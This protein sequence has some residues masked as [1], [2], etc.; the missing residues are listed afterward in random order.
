MSITSVR[1]EP[2]TNGNG[3]SI[4]GLIV[5]RLDLWTSAIKRKS[6][7]GRGSSSKIELYGIKKLRELILELAVRGLLVTQDGNDEPASALLTRIAAEKEKLANGGKGKK[8]KPLPKVGD[9]ECLFQ[10]PGGWSALRLGE[11]VRVIR[12]VSY[13]KQDAQF[14]EFEG[15]VPLL[16]ANNINGQLNFIDLLFIPS[17]LAKPEQLVVRG[18][19]LI[20]MSSGSS[21]LVG[22]AA[23][24]SEDLAST[25]GAFCAVLRPYSE[26]LFSFL[27]FFCKTPLYRS[28]TQA[29]GKGIGIQNLN[30]TGLEMLVAVLPPLAEQHRIV[31]KVDELMALCDQLEQQTEV[32]LSAHQTLVETLLNALTTVVDYDQFASA[33]RRIAE[34]FDTLFTTEE[35]IDQLKQAILQLAVMGKLVPQ[36]PNDEPA[37]KLLKKISNEKAKLV[38]EGKIKKG[39][40]E[41]VNSQSYE[42]YDIP[43]G[44]IWSDLSQVVALVTDGDHQAPPQSADG[45]PFL[46]IGNLNT[47]RINFEACKFVPTDYYAKLDWVRKPVKGDLLYTVTG[48]FGIAVPVDTDKYF[49]VQRHV[50]ILKATDAT[51]V[52][53]LSLALN[54][55]FALE[56]AGS[57]ATGIAQKTVPLTGL[58]RMPIPVA[59]VQEQHRIVEKVNELLSICDSLATQLISARTTQIALTDAV[60]E[61][62]VA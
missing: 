24:A 55:K 17:E 38:M 27:G 33:W 39:K 54:S 36:D 10:L 5:Q 23:Q 37:Y 28:Q 42:P 47:G 45:V 30:K 35:S 12:G 60:V 62:A 11:I 8:A 31:A 6:T 26:D 29:T 25:F 48:S 53:Y 22:K 18:D 7:A 20:A 50:A 9:D 3:S 41:A 43:E 44:W 4:E 13:Q 32:S 51:P 34:H 16:R 14:V 46:V 2:V 56:Y 1:P 15:S 61:Q 40:H 49:C 59:P 57:I 19:L 21:D 52:R 58:R